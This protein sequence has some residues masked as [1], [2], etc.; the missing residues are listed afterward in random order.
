MP[1][2]RSK[3]SHRNDPT[4]DL[5]PRETSAVCPG[6][7]LSKGGVLQNFEY[8]YLPLPH[9]ADPSA[10][11]LYVVA[12][13]R[14]RFTTREEEPEG[15][16]CM[17]SPF[18]TALLPKKGTSPASQASRVSH[19]R[20]S[21]THRA[22]KG[23]MRETGETNIPN[24]VMY[25]WSSGPR[26]PSRSSGSNRARPSPFPRRM[27]GTGYDPEAGEEEKQTHT[28]DKVHEQVPDASHGLQRSDGPRDIEP[29]DN[30]SRD[31][32]SR[33][34]ESS[35]QAILAFT[36][37]VRAQIEAEAQWRESTRPI[38]SFEYR[39]GTAPITVRNL[40]YVGM[41]M[42]MPSVVVLSSACDRTS[43]GETHH[44]AL[45]RI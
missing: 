42:G 5:S 28:A 43:R 21:R 40:R 37:P 33:I 2:C 18:L 29:R 35:Q 10:E 7:V 6:S 24:T 41:L 32:E 26:E 44:V 17:Q 14:R 30:E 9:T 11:V 38:L 34:I 3:V 20:V 25:S 27:T 16:H 45:L 13:R 36:C 31:I 39:I 22:E 23:K 12:L 1:H 8:R 4:S 15:V 19:M